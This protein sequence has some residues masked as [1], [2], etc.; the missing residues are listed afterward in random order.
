M[1]KLKDGGI[2]PEEAFE[3]ML[4]HQWIGMELRYF[5]EELE[6]RKGGK[7]KNKK[8]KRC[9][10]DNHDTSWAVFTEEEMMIL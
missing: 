1:F 9:T 10:Y 2:N 3:I 8:N 5:Q 7:L 6:F 4:E